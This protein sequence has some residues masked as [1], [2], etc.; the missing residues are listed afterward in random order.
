MGVKV[1]ELR[2]GQGVGRIIC[3]GVAIT[4]N[5]DRSKSARDSEPGA[6]IPKE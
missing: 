6:K 5:R 2:S 1:K 3:A 4:G